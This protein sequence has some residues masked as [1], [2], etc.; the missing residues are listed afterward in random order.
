MLFQVKKLIPFKPDYFK[1]TEA[2]FAEYQSRRSGFA[3]K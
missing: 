1:V 3:R 2:L